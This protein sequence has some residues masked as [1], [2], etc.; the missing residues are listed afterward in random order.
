MFGDDEG[1]VV[2]LLVRA[3]ALDFFD[4][5]GQGRLGRVFAVAQEGVDEALFTELFVSGVAGFGY[6]VG[7]KSERVAT[8]K[9]AFANGAIPVLEYAEHGGCGVEALDGAIAAK[10]QTGKMAAIGKTQA[11]CGVVIF[12]KEESGESAV[13]GVVAKEVVYGAHEALGLIESDGALAA[14]IGL[15]IGHQESGGDA[16]SGN[17]A[18]DEAEAAAAKIEEVVIIAANLAGLD[19]KTGVFEGFERRLRLWE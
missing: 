19:A 5:A 2:V 13:G 8:G 3:E 1:D 16:L 4:D 15:Q 7:V 17:V 18:D 10:H 9:V 6:A 12:A 11:A 14:E